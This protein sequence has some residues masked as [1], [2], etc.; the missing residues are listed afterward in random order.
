MVRWRTDAISDGL[1]FYG[2]DVNNLTNVAWETTVTNE[3][4]V[5][6][7]DLQPDTK[8]YYSIGSAAYRLVGGTNDGENYWFQSSPPVGTRRPF[9]FWALGDAG[10]AGNGSPDRQRSTRDAFYNYAATNGGPA[11]L[12][13]MLGDNAYNSG[14][15]SEHQAAVFD[16]YPTTLRNKF[17]WPTLGNHE[18]AQSTTATD[19]PY[20]NIFSLPIGGEAGNVPSG[21]E[22]SYSFG[23][24]NVLDSMTSGRTGTIPMARWLENDL[25]ETAQEWIVV[26]FH[27]SLYTKGTHDRT[28]RATWNCARTSY[29]SWKP[30]AWTSCSWATATS[31]NA[32]I[33]STAITGSPAPS[34]SR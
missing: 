24:G 25:A 22:K 21:A 10:T 6:L 11:D 34:P 29:P 9:R 18:T 7:T 28:P 20:L 3:H 33:C 14:T 5:K 1:V 13:L 15:D 8:Y 16:M 30:T 27:H 17:L 23:Q 19:F 2:T 12:W 26:F 32:P 31:T 4:I